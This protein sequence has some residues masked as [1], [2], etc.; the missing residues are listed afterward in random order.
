MI[1]WFVLKEDIANWLLIRIQES[2]KGRTG[3]V[4][5]SSSKSWLEYNRWHHQDK[6]NKS[7]WLCDILINCH[8]TGWISL[9]TFTQSNRI[10][11]KALQESIWNKLYLLFICLHFNPA[12]GEQERIKKILKLFTLWLIS[13]PHSLRFYSSSNSISVY[14]GKI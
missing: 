9:W 8:A 4:S 13:D 7:P 12:T 2:L 10:Y 1:V 11:E 5:M 14:N 3:Y 6:C